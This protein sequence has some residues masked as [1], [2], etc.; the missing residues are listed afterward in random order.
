MHIS[1]KFQ[2][3]R[4]INT[5]VMQLN[6]F[7]SFRQRCLRSLLVRERE[8]AIA[9]ISC[10]LF[11]NLPLIKGTLNIAIFQNGIKSSV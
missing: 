8:R 9:F 4:S 3:N 11:D 6:V 7:H 2:S 10:F 5:E 1:A